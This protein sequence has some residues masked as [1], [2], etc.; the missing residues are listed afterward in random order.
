MLVSL[1]LFCALYSGSGLG[2]FVSNLDD[3]SGASLALPL[4]TDWGGI[5]SLCFGSK[6]SW[7]LNNAG[8][9]FF[10]ISDRFLPQQLKQAVARFCIICMG[11]NWGILAGQFSFCFAIQVGAEEGEKTQE[12]LLYG[13]LSDVCSRL[14]AWVSECVAVLHVGIE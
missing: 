11:M 6:G 8:M 14:G 3:T 4:S 1:S 10:S 13:V 12:W 7:V 9:I 5:F 2:R